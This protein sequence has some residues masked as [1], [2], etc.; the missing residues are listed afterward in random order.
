MWDSEDSGKQGEVVH[1]FEG[2]LFASFKASQSSIEA[3]SKG[4]PTQKL[5]VC[6]IKCCIF[7]CLL[8]QKSTFL[9]ASHI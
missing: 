8:K 3:L 6:Y 1:I 5:C 2:K 7:P 9:F 4:S